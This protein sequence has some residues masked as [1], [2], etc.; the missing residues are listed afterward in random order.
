MLS[1]VGSGNNLSSQFNEQPL[2]ICSENS[3][4]TLTLLLK[5][6]TKIIYS[7]LEYYFSHWSISEA[8]RNEHYDKHIDD[9]VQVIYK[10]ETAF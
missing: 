8:I 5:S 9:V 6:I 4:P 3:A 7:D 10:I 1:V 2:A